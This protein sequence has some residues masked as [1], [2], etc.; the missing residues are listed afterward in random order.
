MLVKKG[1]FRRLVSAELS[2]HQALFLKD[3]QWIF[4]QGSS[5]VA[6]RLERVNGVAARGRKIN[7]L[8]G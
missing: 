7:V 5:G 2:H 3:I 6:G 4:S 1:E 8:K